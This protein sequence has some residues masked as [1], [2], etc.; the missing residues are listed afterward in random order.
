MQ[1]RNP[2]TDSAVSFWQNLSANEKIMVGIGGGVLLVGTLAAIAVAT[3]DAPLAKRA[4]TVAPGC[5][6]FTIVDMQMLRD[7]LRGRAREA[8]SRGP[9]DPFTVAS[10]YV[11]SIAPGCR[12][13]PGNTNLPSEVKLFAAVMITL[14]DVMRTE[15]MLTSGDETT[16][17]EM[18]IAWA[19]G[20][21]V[22][23]ADLVE[24][25]GTQA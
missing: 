20:Q 3:T 23:E 15:Q 19:S 24:S 8:A 1:L 16:W 14:L 25:N 6:S 17:Y 5:T 9:A 18:L 13:Y 22:A 10:R 21:G 11:K 12:T 7:D 4:I 2:A